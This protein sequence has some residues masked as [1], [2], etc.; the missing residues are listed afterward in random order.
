M[1]VFIIQYD[2]DM[3]LCWNTAI[4]TPQDNKQTK[5]L[6]IKGTDSLMNRSDINSE[7]HYTLGMH[8]IPKI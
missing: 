5:E 2:L 8:I 3:A 7:K 1:W 6:V 4:Q